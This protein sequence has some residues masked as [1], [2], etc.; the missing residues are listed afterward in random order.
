MA[1]PVTITT[2]TRTPRA[3]VMGTVTEPT[4]AARRALSE[5]EHRRCCVC[6]PEAEGG[7][8]VRFET[9]ADGAVRADWRSRPGDQSYAGVLHGGVIATLLDAAMVQALFAR[10][11]TARTAELRVRYRRPVRAGAAVRVS[12]RLR[13]RFGA[14]YVV[15]AE[16]RQDEALC[17]TAEG[18]FM[19]AAG[20]S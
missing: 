11:V 6:G 18:R 1:G 13:R 10:G 4:E 17:V 2:I 9:A 14:L 16:L 15:A 3:I 7:W 8:H 12:A 19:A 20:A 5:R